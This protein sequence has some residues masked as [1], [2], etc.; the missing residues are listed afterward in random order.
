MPHAPHPA[1]PLGL[2]PTHIPSL[3]WS[4]CGTSTLEPFFHF[5]V[6]PLR[7][8]YSLSAASTYSF[9]VAFSAATASLASLA[10]SLASRRA[11]MPRCGAGRKQGL[12]RARAAYAAVRP[13][14]A[15]RRL[16]DDGP[17]LAAGAAWSR[18]D[19]SNGCVPPHDTFGNHGG[20]QGAASSKRALGCAPRAECCAGQIEAK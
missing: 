14:T 20:V 10:A 2:S 15:C 13:T 4:V 9:A 6:P 11:L 17:P 19:R 7:G 18:V 16:T 5:A 8:L 1:C 12:L 3:T